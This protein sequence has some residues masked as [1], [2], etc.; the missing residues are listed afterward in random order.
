MKRISPRETPWHGGLSLAK[1][2]LVSAE[3]HCTRLTLGISQSTERCSLSGDMPLA[4]SSS[5]G[6]F[7]HLDETFFRISH[8]PVRAGG[9]K[10]HSPTT[11]HR[12]LLCRNLPLHLPFCQLLGACGRDQGR[13][14]L[15]MQQ[16]HR[17]GPRGLLPSSWSKCK[18]HRLAEGG[19]THPLECLLDPQMKS[20]LVDCFPRLLIWR[21]EA[22]LAGL[23]NLRVWPLL[24]DLVFSPFWFACNIPDSSESPD[25]T[26]R[27]F[28]FHARAYA[29]GMGLQ[30]SLRQSAL[31][32]LLRDGRL[33]LGARITF[34]APTL[35]PEGPQLAQVSNPL[36]ARSLHS[37]ALQS[38]AGRVPNHTIDLKDS[39]FFPMSPNRQH[40]FL[41]AY[42]LSETLKSRGL[43][44]LVSDV[45]QNLSDGEE[46]SMA[47]LRLSPDNLA[48]AKPSTL[49]GG[50]LG[51]V[52][53][54]VTCTFLRLV[55]A[56]SE[57]DRWWLLMHDF[58][59]YLSANGGLGKREFNKNP[60]Q[61]SQC[62]ST[63]TAVSDR[64]IR[65][66]VKDKIHP[67]TFETLKEYH[68]ILDASNLGFSTQIVERSEIEGCGSFQNLG[69][70]LRP[71]ISK[72]VRFAI[73]PSKP[74]QQLKLAY[75]N[76]L[77]T[78]ASGFALLEPMWPPPPLKTWG[79]LR[80]PNRSI[81]EVVFGVFGILGT[82]GPTSELLDPVSSHQF[83]QATLILVNPFPISRYFPRFQARSAINT[84]GLA[85]TGSNR[86]R[87]SSSFRKKS[88]D[89]VT[90]SYK[91]QKFSLIADQNAML[92]ISLYSTTPGPIHRHFSGRIPVPR[93]SGY[94]M[95]NVIEGYDVERCGIEARCMPIRLVEGL[96][97]PFTRN[98]HSRTSSPESAYRAAGTRNNSDNQSCRPHNISETPQLILTRRAGPGDPRTKKNAISIGSRI[99]LLPHKAKIL[100]KQDSRGPYFSSSTLYPII[101]SVM[102]SVFSAL[103]GSLE[104]VEPCSQNGNI[105]ILIAVSNKRYPYPTYLNSETSIQLATDPQT[106]DVKRQHTL[107]PHPR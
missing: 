24:Q 58:T 98:K 48:S 50:N 71:T 82:V 62:L 5:L 26:L 20:A 27:N 56:F 74:P 29:V 28:S 30:E 11:G 44:K 19:S 33:V 17:Q 49:I 69:R 52:V 65:I 79:A 4:P 100:C 8:L 101:L 22:C 18:R 86:F 75:S 95:K 92:N 10:A 97:S 36:T 102:L 84:I 106:P 14:P 90:H 70:H 38:R 94:C 3:H 7:G 105:R 96:T 32:C 51:I 59:M 66:P 76:A 2:K 68:Y 93:E 46:N 23:A 72:V 21:A 54:L 31:C 40:R 47:P 9:P 87:K 91:P 99:R 53:F 107:Y 78:H 34:L 15:W 81:I 104:M 57:L 103:Y 16:P 77:I 88:D 45:F 85:Q 55:Q 43:D 73:R 6:C 37:S 41:I 61:I 80:L 35:A 13:T 67:Y 63:R 64:N 42:R 39:S 83:A 12:L 1:T 89:N 25:Q 60:P